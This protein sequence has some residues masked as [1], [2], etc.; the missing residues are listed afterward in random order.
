MKKLE[1]PRDPIEAMG[2][3]YEL[4]LEKI[5]EK[6]YQSRTAVHSIIDEIVRDIVAVYKFTD[7]EAHMLEEFVKR[8]LTDAAHYVDRTGKELKEWLGFDVS[9]IKQGFWQRFSEAADPTT[10]ALYDLKR[11]GEKTE[12][13]SGELVG[14]GTLVCDR[15]GENLHFHKPGRIPPCPRCYGASFQRPDHE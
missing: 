7:D 4:L 10:L 15:C 13:R 5:L 9:L 2:Q 3:A 6:T 14:L 11:Q 12:Y 8:D 1:P